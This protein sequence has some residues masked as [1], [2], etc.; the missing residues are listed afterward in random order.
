[1][2]NHITGFTAGRVKMLGCGA[3]LEHD[4]NAGRTYGQTGVCAGLSYELT[5]LHM[6]MWGC[7]RIY[8][9]DFTDLQGYFMDLR[10]C[11]PSVGLSYGSVGLYIRT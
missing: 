2:A 8:P 9:K 11:I 5:D 7:I 4:K 10:I 1:M 6:D 3:D